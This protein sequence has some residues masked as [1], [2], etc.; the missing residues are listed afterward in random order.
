MDRNNENRTK[1]REQYNQY[2]K[3]WRARSGWKEYAHAY[4][5]RN[6]E[7]LLELQRKDPK[8][9]EKK[10]V[11]WHRRKA[12]LLGNGGNHTI[13]EWEELKAKNKGL[14]VNCKQERKLTK[15]HIQSLH[16]GGTNDISNIQPLCQS[17]NSKKGKN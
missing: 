6:K 5:V 3:D 2:Q 15:D 10:N 7:R 1:K 8:Y 11:I 4:Y 13:R 16:K 17:C 9:L 12:R 14:C